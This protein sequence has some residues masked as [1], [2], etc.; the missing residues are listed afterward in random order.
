MRSQ[1]IGPPTAANALYHDICMVTVI[2]NSIFSDI[3]ISKK[4]TFAIYVQATW[5]NAAQPESTI[6]HCGR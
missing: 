2:Y 1:Y 5:E 3:Y 4:I 6:I